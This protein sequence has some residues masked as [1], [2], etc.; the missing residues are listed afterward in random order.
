M[1]RIIVVTLIAFV[2][3]FMSSCGS[4]NAGPNSDRP[5]A[6]IQM[7]DGSTM[8]GVISATSPSEIIL[9]GDDNTTH[10]LPTAQVKSVEYDEAPSPPEPPV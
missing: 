6:T 4:K 1:L 8:T 7:R 2:V 9:N 3:S 10:T 5:H